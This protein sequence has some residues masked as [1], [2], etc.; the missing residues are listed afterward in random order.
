MKS[1]EKNMTKKI[2]EFIQAWDVVVKMKIEENSG[3]EL[4]Q[5]L[6]NQRQAKAKQHPDSPVW[7]IYNWIS[8]DSNGEV[9]PHLAKRRFD[10]IQEKTKI[11]TNSYPISAD[12][13]D[14]IC[15]LYCKTYEHSNAVDSNV[16]R[17]LPKLLQ[18][19]RIERINKEYHPV[20]KDKNKSEET[21]AKLG[22][23]NHDCF[24]SISANTYMISYNLT[25][26]P[27]ITVDFYRNFFDN[28]YFAIYT[29][30]GY[31]YVHLKGD[32]ERCINLGSKLHQTVRNAYLI[33]EDIRRKIELEKNKAM[34]NSNKIILHIDTD[35]LMKNENFMM[36]LEKEKEKTSSKLKK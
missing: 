26:I 8:V 10:D 12:I 3:G 30:Q 15:S 7:Y 1:K 23:L 14:Y 20:F 36:D 31:I 17:I 6:I 5:M 19:K 18:N 27:D 21:L 32:S 22:D 34:K 35:A 24:L 11:R 29:Y 2:L 13:T 16:R 28:D 9:Q 25:T 4:N 33:Q